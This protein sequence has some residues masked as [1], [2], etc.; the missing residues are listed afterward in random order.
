MSSSSSSSPR[1]WKFDLSVSSNL[2]SSTRRFPG[3]NNSD[4]GTTTRN[5]TNTKNHNDDDSDCE[6]LAFKTVLDLAALLRSGQTTSVE[7]V[8]VYAARIR[9]LDSA[10]EAVVTLTE[11]LALEQAR[12]ADAELARGID[13]GPL[14][15]IPFGLKDTM[16]VEELP[17]SFGAAIWRDRVFPRGSSAAAYRAL[18]ERAGAVLVAK[19]ATGELA[20]DDIW[21]GGR[22]SNP[23][24]AEARQSFSGGSSAGPAAAVSAALVGFALGTE[25]QGSLV[26]PA[27]RC[28]ATALRPTFGALDRSGVLLLA[29]SVDKVGPVCR[30]A[31]DCSAVYEALLRGG[32]GGVGGESG[33]GGGGTRSAPRG[34]SSASDSSS[35]PLPVPISLDPSYNAAIR[36]RVDPSRVDLSRLRI[37]VLPSISGG[38][39]KGK[40]ENS[41]SSSSDLDRLSRALARAGVVAPLVT[42]FEIKY[43]SP[44][45]DIMTTILISEASS[46]LDFWSR[47]GESARVARQ[48]FWPPLLRLAQLV[49]AA[50]YLHA[51]RA[52]GA[53]AA[54]VLGS[55]RDAGVDALVGEAGDLLAASNLVGLPTV[56]APLAF[57]DDVVGGGG[58]ETAK[59]KSPRSVAFSRPRTMTA[60]R[61]P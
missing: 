36:H 7:L 17:T 43:S 59:R 18:T 22:V 26:T 42:D 19:L 44:A 2:T 35:P 58:G 50:R 30:S 48:D 45:S 47:S 13:R 10:L 55:M 38:K 23:G 61:L 56:V 53:L 9:A 15:G 6:S 37:G 4:D 27:A 33:G 28:G 25:T 24:D 49:P 21:F 54:E 52:R 34:V 29:D 8:R 31:A 51:Q 60:L 57:D 20:F 46:N 40:V 39:K 12:R 32:D 41:S 1:R 14:H 3:E 5:N 16:V 11:E